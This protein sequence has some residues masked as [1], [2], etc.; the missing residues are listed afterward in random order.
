MTQYAEDGVEFSLQALC[1]SPLLSIP[2]KMAEHIKCLKRVEGMLDYENTDW[3]EFTCSGPPLWQ[4]ADICGLTKDIMDK[5][6]LSQPS[7]NLIQDA[8]GN[9]EELMRLHQQLSLDIIESRNS[10]MNEL[11]T[12]SNENEQAAVLMAG[13]G[14]APREHVE[15]PTQDHYDHMNGGST[16]SNADLHTGDIP[17][18]P[19][20]EHEPINI[21]NDDYLLEDDG[22]SSVE[23]GSI[24][25]AG[26]EEPKV[27]SN[28][29]MKDGQ[30]SVGN[31]GTATVPTGETE[32]GPKWKE[33]TDLDTK[34]SVGATVS[35]FEARNMPTEETEPH[36]IVEDTEDDNVEEKEGV[37]DSDVTT[38]VIPPEG[39]GS[40]IPAEASHEENQTE[41][42]QNAFQ[43]QS[44][45]ETQRGSEEGLR[46][47][48]DSQQ[49]PQSSLC[50][51]PKPE[52]IQ[53]NTAEVGSLGDR[54]T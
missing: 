21:A 7:I 41:M 10:Y 37:S 26:A 42:A 53:V 39:R 27:G 51:S 1:K 46:E 13:D 20:K 18:D 6:R 11:V 28:E 8:E 45:H 44:S 17:L 14:A 49:T 50:N 4:D 22:D 43:V 12:I 31:I 34:A 48:E 15:A 33:T 35:S 3:K 9:F 24:E 30:T 29:H 54:L 47:I 25:R 40:T 52:S 36:R 19:R 16:T 32:S 38:R 23:D 2:P 5:V